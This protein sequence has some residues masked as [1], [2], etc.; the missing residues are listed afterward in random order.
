MQLAWIASRDK[1]CAFYWDYFQGSMAM[2]MSIGC[3]NRE[4]ARRALF[5][6]GFLDDAEG[7]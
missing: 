6:L 7:R 1:T 3:D 4:T 5:L 2:P